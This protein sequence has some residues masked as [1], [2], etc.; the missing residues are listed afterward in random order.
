MPKIGHKPINS[1]LQAALFDLERF[2]ETKL[3][4]LGN[5]AGVAVKLAYMLKGQ[6]GAII[7]STEYIEIQLPAKQDTDTG[8]KASRPGEMC[9]VPGIEICLINPPGVKS[10]I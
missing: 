5:S 4:A 3:K 10:H 8:S 7:K 1:Y 6:T 2:G 9:T